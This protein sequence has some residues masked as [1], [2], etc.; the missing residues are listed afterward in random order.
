[1]RTEVV[2]AQTTREL[3][4]AVLR[5]AWPSGS[6]MHGDDRPAAVHIAAIDDDTMVGACVLLPAAYPL[7]PQAADAWQLR[8]MATALD[9]RGEGIGTAVLTEA[10]RQVR[11]RGGSLIWCQAREM[12]VA[13]YAR[14][15]FAAEG[16]QFLHAETGILHRLMYREL[17]DPTGSSNP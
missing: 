3:R 13:F 11:L 5:P 12:A 14:H 15:G 8:G 16:D 9:R 17:S 7:R 1:M 4:R 2:D 6:Q 10:L